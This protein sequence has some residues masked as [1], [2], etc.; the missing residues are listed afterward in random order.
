MSQ[1][2]PAIDHASR[3]RPRTAAVSLALLHGLAHLPMPVLHVLGNLVGWVG[4][5]MARRSMRRAG[6]TLK[7]ALP[8]LSDAE[9]LQLARRSLRH[10]GCAGMEFGLM[11]GAGRARI[12]RLVKRV[13]GRELFEQAV[14]EGRGVL[15]L[16]MHLGC[17]EMVG[18]W[19]S[20][21][22][23]VT[24]MYRPPRVRELDD[25]LRVGRSRFGATLVAAGYDAVRGLHRG[26]R[27]GH[28]CVLLPDQDPG[29]GNGIF[30]PFLGAP[31]NTG[32]LAARLI[33]RNNPVVLLGRA[34]RLPWG[35]GLEL[36]FREAPEA[37]YSQDLEEATVA[38]NAAVG[39]MVREFPEQ[40]LWRYRRYRNGPQGYLDPY[41]LDGLPKKSSSPGQDG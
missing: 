15:L 36:E 10:V 25:A 33:A 4:S 34:K 19:A 27:A 26:L 41:R 14:A 23:A 20:M 30:V 1:R 29:A 31:A 37:C 9:R 32:T 35:R 13:I 6:I 7:L 11:F 28:I 5:R 16:N 22:H 2:G 3:S 21:Q 40:Y 18:I 17:W 24:G 8:E 12:N 38:I 39:Q